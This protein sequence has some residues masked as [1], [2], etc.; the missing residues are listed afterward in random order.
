MEH[1]A[2]KAIRRWA[3]LLA[4]VPAVVGMSLASV[5][6]AGAATAAK[7]HARSLPTVHESLVIVTGGMTGHS[8]WPEYVGSK[9]IDFPAHTKVVLTIYS[10]DD[11]AAP[12]AKSLQIYDK[13]AGTLGHTETVD[14][15]K[16]SSVP[17]KDV[18][19]TF[20]VPGIGLNLAVPAAKTSKSGEITPTV[21]TASFVT[22]KEGTFTWQCYAPCGSGKG[23]MSGA[24][25]TP[26]YMT[27]KVVIH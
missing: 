24:M 11:G 19:H 8:G 3:P 15:K 27:G 1:G 17:N 16:V 21:V 25:A 14:G 5:S 18:A 10:F 13:V 7:R 2:S 12:L 26:G 4:G 23:G 20:T 9:R 6:P 22:E